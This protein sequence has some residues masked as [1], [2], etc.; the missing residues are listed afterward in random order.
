MYHKIRITVVSLV[1]VAITV[2]S[3]TATLSYFTDTDGA[4]NNF[5]VGNASTK[6]VIY[7]NAAGGENNLFE[8]S[9]YTLTDKLS[10][11]LYLQAENNG[12][13]PVYQRFR[14]VIPITLAGV[15][16]LNL[17]EMDDNCTIVTTSENT[18][19]NDDYTVTYKPTVSVDNA[20]E[21]AEYYIVS[22]SVLAKDDKTVKWPTTGLY[23]DGLSDANKALFTCE[24]GDNSCVLGIGIYSDAIQTTGFTNGAVSAFADFPETY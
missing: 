16:T 22:N 24:A 18:C 4:T 1:V 17:P 8:A 13:I 12:N 10:I 3:S 23:I 15:V 9:D 5:V 2:L 7:N 19:S 20:P 14:V 11:P 21:Y 6:L